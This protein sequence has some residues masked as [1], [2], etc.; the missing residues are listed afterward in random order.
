MGLS[1]FKNCASVVYRDRIINLNPNPKN[2][3]IEKLLEL[4]NTYAEIHYPDCPTFEGLK[5]M[6]FKGKVAERLLAAKEIDPH[7]DDKGG[8]SPMARFEPTEYGKWLG[9]QLAKGAPE[10]AA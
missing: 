2:F 1:P 6:V 4:E 8:L 5:V 10:K 7:F 3:K 9:V